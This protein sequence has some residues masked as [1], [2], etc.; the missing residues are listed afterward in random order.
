MKTKPIAFLEQAAI[1]DW[2]GTGTLVLEG[3]C[4][5]HEF[6][7]DLVHRWIHTS[8]IVNKIDAETFETRNSIYKIKSWGHE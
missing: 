2:H 1:V 6:R 3:H 8:E 4:L 7:S 5:S